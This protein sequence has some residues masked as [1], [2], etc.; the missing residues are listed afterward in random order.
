MAPSQQLAVVVGFDKTSYS[1]KSI[2]VPQPEDDEVL[3]KVHA[4]AQ[5]PTDCL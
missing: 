4:T 5:N 1:V 3:V 2:D